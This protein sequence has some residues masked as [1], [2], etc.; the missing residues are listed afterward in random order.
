MDLCCFRLS[1]LVSVVALKLCQYDIG[2]TCSMLSF[3]VLDSS[4]M[5][6]KQINNKVNYCYTL[7]RKAKTHNQSTA[8]QNVSVKCIDCNEYHQGNNNPQVN[9]SLHSDRLS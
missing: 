8:K 4:L 6:N 9:M 7:R 1:L 2:Y 5:K 3:V